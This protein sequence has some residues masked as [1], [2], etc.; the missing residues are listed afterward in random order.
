MSSELTAS[1][2]HSLLSRNIPELNY[3]TFIREVAIFPNGVRA[4]LTKGTLSVDDLGRSE[5]VHERKA[6]PPDYQTIDDD[7]KVGLKTINPD[8]A[9]KADPER[10]RKLLQYFER[11]AGIW[12]LTS[13][14]PN[15]LKLYGFVRITGQI[16]PSLVSPYLG[17]G[18]LRLFVEGSDY[19]SLPARQR[20][21]LMCDI[22]RGISF[23]H[24]LSPIIVHRDIRASNALVRREAEGFSAVLIDFG[25]AKLSD[26]NLFSI[27]RSTYSS[28]KAW[29]PPEYILD[30]EQYTNPATHG[31]IWSLACTCIEV[32]TTK[33]PYRG[34]DAEDALKNGQIPDR[35]SVIKDATW[36]FLQSCLSFLP[37]ERPDAGTAVSKLEDLVAIA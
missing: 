12:R 1:I 15:I 6:M 20:L 33:D 36:D 34:C 2:V 17:D 21:K 10:Q 31:D 30:P 7:E 37:T 27:L 26:S 11:E 16:F 23:L 13:G 29:S 35:P 18:D 25:S 32:F 4:V 24:N 9:R 8:F 28:S 19:V 22:A 3:S 5:K 14:H